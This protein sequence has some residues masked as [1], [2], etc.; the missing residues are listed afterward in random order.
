ML[1]VTRGSFEAE[2]DGRL[3]GPRQAARPAPPFA[4]AGAHSGHLVYLDP[5]LVRRPEELGQHTSSL[6]TKCAPLS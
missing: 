4:R 2:A 3:M 6:E 5:K 1:P